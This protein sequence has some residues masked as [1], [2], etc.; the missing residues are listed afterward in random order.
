MTEDIDNSR[1]MSPVGKLLWPLFNNVISLR[2]CQRFL[3]K[4]RYMYRYT[5]VFWI[6]CFTIPVW[7]HNGAQSELVVSLHTLSCI[8]KCC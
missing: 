5:A 4:Y 8:V 7:R 1:A 2:S 6:P 3:M